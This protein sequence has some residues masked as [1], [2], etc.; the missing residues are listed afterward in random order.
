LRPDGLRALARLDVAREESGIALGLGWFEAESFQ[1]PGAKAPCATR[2][3]DNDAEIWIKG[4]ESADPDRPRYICLDLQPGPSVGHGPFIL[5]ARD[6]SGNLLHKQA[7]FQRQTFC[8]PVHIA[9]DKLDKITLHADSQRLP[10][11]H[12]HDPRTLNFLVFAVDVRDA[13]PDQLTSPDIA[14]PGV[15][16]GI[17]WYGAEEIDGLIQR[18]A[19]NDAEVW[20]EMPPEGQAQPRYLALDI[21]P[22][23]GVGQ[24]PFLLRVGDAENP[25]F[26]QCAVLRR[27][28]VNIPLALAPD[29]LHRLRLSLDS[30]NLP[31]AGD[32]RLL[33]FRSRGMALSADPVQSPTIPDI[34]AAEAPI[35]FGTG[36]YGVESTESGV[37][38]WLD[39]N[40][41]LWIV[42][43]A[44]GQPPPRYLRL[45]LQPGPSVGHEP[46]VLE[47]GGAVA[48]QR[49]SYP[50][51]ARQT[52][53]I[54]LALAPGEI[55]RVT[56]RLDSPRCPVPDDPRTLNALLL[57]AELSNEPAPAAK[58]ETVA[59]VA[60]PGEIRFG[61]GW[62]SPETSG[63]Q[64]LRW[65]D[66]DAVLWIAAPGEPPEPHLE[67]ELEPGPSLGKQPLLL[68][69]VDVEGK[70]VASERLSERR[71][72][73]IRLPQGA[74]PLWKLTLTT[75]TPR[76]AVKNDSR[77][78]NFALYRA[79]LTDGDG[80]TPSLSI[81]DNP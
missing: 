5:R 58:P 76:L 68:E 35:A 29:R 42:P 15:G 11:G 53:S 23:P 57:G 24:R 46:F 20:I 18:W 14:G 63:G 4:P 49:L 39:N 36:I 73:R 50:I 44:G 65:A 78:L 70:P 79:C 55:N 69:I 3:V 38:R 52:I 9:P 62:F 21:E 1:P 75:P 34:M 19:T 12:H 61:S 30:P 25:A 10:A 43:D 7:I 47:V 45:D 74:R 8:F 2:W 80:L 72:I 31:Y 54:P 41:D 17:G 59:D 6:A 77:I 33:N 40:A 60:D 13:P 66:N 37:C 64:W 28:T 48:E 51:L 16:A 22:G 32:T 71:T 26:F 27:Q 67:L 56:L 81:G